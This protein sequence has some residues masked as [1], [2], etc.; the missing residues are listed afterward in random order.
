[1]KY[2]QL[3]W[4][5][6]EN[7]YNCFDNLFMI[8][9]IISFYKIWW[10]GMA[11]N[12]RINNLIYCL[13][14]WR[15]RTFAEH[16]KREYWKGHEI[17]S[18]VIVDR[19]TAWASKERFIACFKNIILMSVSKV[20]HKLYPLEFHVKMSLWLSIDFGTRRNDSGIR[21]QKSIHN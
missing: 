1:M 5:Y 3:L 17:L 14:N 12:N 20:R 16:V 13:T 10:N 18:V 2:L 6:D 15:K 8:D 9:K 21:I 19:K 7:I 4:H 11:G